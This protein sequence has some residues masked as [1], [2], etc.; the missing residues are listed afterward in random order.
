M[1]AINSIYKAMAQDFLS[2]KVRAPYYEIRSI[3]DCCPVDGWSSLEPFSEEEMEKLL[4]LREKYG[5]E[6][7]FN[8]LD[9]VFD[10]DTICDL[11]PGYIIDI[12]L[13]TEYYMYSFRYHQITDR[14]VVSGTVKINLTDE[15]YIKLLAMHLDN[16]DLNI[17]NLRY[18]D[19]YL[20]D[21]V[22]HGVDGNFCYDGIYEVADPYTVTMDEIRADAQKVREQHPEKFANC[23]GIAGYLI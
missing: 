5:R 7:F 14:G 1:A 13:D 20:Y 22:M 6:E 17:N 18:A 12:D 21:V 2:T 3:S 23:H 8:H 15:T 9:E 4:A 11:A 10:E 16:K 19:K